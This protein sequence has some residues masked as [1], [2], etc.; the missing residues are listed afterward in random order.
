MMQAANDIYLGWKH[1]FWDL[2]P[3]KWTPGMLA[4]RDKEA[5]HG[6]CVDARV[7]MRRDLD[8]VGSAG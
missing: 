1:G 6:L 3:A 7:F 5:L 8:G 4:I 2:P